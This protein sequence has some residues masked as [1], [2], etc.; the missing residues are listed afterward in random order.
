[1][2]GRLVA[3]KA[4]NAL[5][6][7]AD[8]K[9]AVRRFMPTIGFSLD[10]LRAFQEGKLWVG[11]RLLVFEDRIQF[12]ANWG[13][14]LIQTGTDGFELPWRAISDVK[15]KAGLLTSIIELEHDGR[16]EAVRCF[17]SKKLL[18]AI[19]SLRAANIS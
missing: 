10:L 7:A 5:I 9:P 6:A 19:Q 14:R 18:K 4:A 16:I 1:M 11:G 15:W 2:A 13:N 17:G 8:I 3:S 12:T